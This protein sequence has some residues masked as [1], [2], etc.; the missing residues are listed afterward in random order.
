V[1]SNDQPRHRVGAWLCWRP[2]FLQGAPREVIDGLL[3]LQDEF[4]GQRRYLDTMLTYARFG[5]ARRK[6]GPDFLL[7]VRSWC[8]QAEEAR[9]S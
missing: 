3:A 8:I 7:K 5:V 4:P 1:R 6:L 2:A 9:R